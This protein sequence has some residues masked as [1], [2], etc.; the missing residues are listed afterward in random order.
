M[1]LL[2]FSKMTSTRGAIEKSKRPVS[3]IRGLRG[4]KKDDYSLML[5]SK[6]F[7]CTRLC[8]SSL[9]CELYPLLHDSS[10]QPA[11]REATASCTIYSWS[12]HL[13]EKPL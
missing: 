5:I 2:N 7:S 8:P 10:L 4:I 13:Q 11:L 12:L 3:V 1:Y 9:P 6:G